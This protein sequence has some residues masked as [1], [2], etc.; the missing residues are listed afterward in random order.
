MTRSESSLLKQLN[1][2]LFL[3]FHP[4]SPAALFRNPYRLVSNLVARVLNAGLRL[5]DRLR[6][7]PRVACSL[8]GWQGRR[9]GYWAAVSANQLLPDQLCFRC[10]STAQT[11]VLVKLFEQHLPAAK[12]KPAVL[13]IGPS[14]ATRQY[15]AQHP[16]LCYVA[17]DRFKWV[18]VRCDATHIAL[19][20][21][22]IDAFICSNVL[23]HIPDDRQAL[24]ELYRTLKP[25]GIGI[26]VVPQTK[27]LTKSHRVRDT[28]FL[29]YGHIWEYGDDFAQRIKEVGYAVQAA[30]TWDTDSGP[31]P[32]RWGPFYLVRRP[33]DG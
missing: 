24:S 28:T 32:V 13:E 20:P 1:L 27:G 18:D 21:R 30:H 4:Q 23:E 26:I 8:C 12:T 19:R 9:F 31:T 7:E 15:F 22:T 6:P 29:G 14:P 17:V 3:F 33:A 16:E 5:Q 10:G 11:R 25:D 2:G